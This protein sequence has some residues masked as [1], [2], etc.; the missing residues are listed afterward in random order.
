MWLETTRQYFTMRPILR[1]VRNKKNFGKSPTFV[2]VYLNNHNCLFIVRGWWQM[3]SWLLEKS[4]LHT[5][6]HAFH[7][8]MHEGEI[9]KCKARSACIFLN[10]WQIGN[11]F[12]VAPYQMLFNWNSIY[13]T[14]LHYLVKILPVL[15]SVQSSL[16][17]NASL[18][19]W[20]TAGAQLMC[21]VQCTK[22]HLVHSLHPY[23]TAAD[24]L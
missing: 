21:S 18:T 12:F 14:M 13:C 4:V 24:M 17:I 22:M 11:A 23:S 8:V 10:V 19:Q 7:L 9:K 15:K 2:I 16:I 5:P 3:S 1:N 6:P 20:C